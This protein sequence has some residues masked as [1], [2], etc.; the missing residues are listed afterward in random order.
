MRRAEENSPATFASF[1]N[2]GT[3]R[4]GSESVRFGPGPRAQSSLF[5]IFSE[6]D[7]LVPACLVLVAGRAAVISP[8]WVQVEPRNAR[9]L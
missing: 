2:T 4:L 6:H 3:Q 1:E 7:L 9:H 8:C 5:G